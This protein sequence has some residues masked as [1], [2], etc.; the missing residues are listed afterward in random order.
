MPWIKKEL[1]DFYYF[2]FGIQDFSQDALNI[3]FQKVFQKCGFK[4]D[5]QQSKSDI[6]PEKSIPLSKK[7]KFFLVWAFLWCKAYFWAKKQA[8]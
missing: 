7:K 3:D 2:V 1:S 6:H 5:C 4:Y 8:P